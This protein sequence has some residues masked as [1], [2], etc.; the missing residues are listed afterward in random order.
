MSTSIR[1]QI[2]ESS[3]ATR[4]NCN[5]AAESPN[6]KPCSSE[7][8]EHDKSGQRTPIPWSKQGVEDVSWHR[9]D[10]ELQL[11]FFHCLLEHE[12]GQFGIASLALEGVHSGDCRRSE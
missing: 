2:A 10:G 6:G 1:R 9:G 12:A 3:E 7:S 4:L 11:Y 8:A 5:T